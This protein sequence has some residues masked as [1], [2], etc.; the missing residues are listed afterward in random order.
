MVEPAGPVPRFSVLLPTHNRADVLPFAI[1]S[2]LWQTVHEF[3]LLIV[4]DG[5]TDRTADVVGSFSDHRIRWFDFPKAPNFGYAN[6]NVA[7]REASGDHIAYMCH[8]DL[9]LPDHL[10][11]LSAC[12]DQ[13]GAELAYSRTLW[14]APDGTI[15]PGTFNL[16]HPETL[17]PFLARTS[18]RIPSG[19][20]VHRRECF[21]KYGYW[22]EALPSCGDWDLWARIIDGGKQRNFAYLPVPTYLHFRASWRREADVW[23]PELTVW[24]ALYAR[25]GGMPSALRIRLEPGL[26]E[27]EATWRAMAPDAH[28]W[29]RELRAAVDQILDC[30][31]SQMDELM[32]K[33]LAGRPRADEDPTKLLETLVQLGAERESSFGWK[34]VRR[35]RQVRHRVAPPGT[36][37]ERVWR[38]LSKAAARVL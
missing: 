37:R 18:N 27:Q 19:C 1:R 12:L 20:V 5:C 30:R 16:N 13:Y 28:R 26:T 15:M 17:G 38:R 4:G 3:E 32:L 8:D 29:A 2:V 21:V 22:N 6:R 10:E 25:A 9:W 23:P 14:V 35:L 24:K 11:L 31:V 7:L 36:L 33:V 34:L